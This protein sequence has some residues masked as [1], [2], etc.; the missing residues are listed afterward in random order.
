[1]RARLK[2]R[3]WGVLASTLLIIAVVATV[4]FSPVQ[5]SITEE[6][7]LSIETKYVI[8]ASPADLYEYYNTGDSG[9]DAIYGSRW[10]AQTFTPSTAHT[11]TS[12]KLELFRTGSP[13]TVT[14]S[15]KATSSDKPSG[16]D[17]CSGTTNGN[18]LPTGSPYEWREITLGSGYDLSASTMYAVV[19]RISGG[20][21]GNCIK[22]RA[23]KTSPT[24]TGGTA[25]DSRN[26]GSSWSIR[27]GKDFM[28][29][30]WG[31][32]IGGEPNISNTPTS[33]NF[34]TVKTD[35]EYDT[36]LTYFA[37]TNNSGAAV[38]ITI[39][40]TDMTGG[41]AWTLSDTATQGSDTVG[42]KAGTSSSFMTVGFAND[43][44]MPII[45]SKNT[46]GSYL[47]AGLSGEGY[48]T[49]IKKN[50]PYNY[51][52]Q[53]LADAATQRWG[54]RLLTPTSYSDSNTKTGT[55]TLTATLS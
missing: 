17:L 8:L 42:L 50:T 48:T 3:A 31:D 21:S 43:T 30:D 38:D 2:P 20:S 28:F 55:V 23:D 52:V 39:Q 26:S 15:I 44:S 41:T 47:I 7:R 10:R 29:E 13:G 45:E 6:G 32:P 18:T 49:I 19:V 4:L 22:W 27:T 9:Q 34:G 40:G 37:V 5:I 46:T 24:Y 1:M 54:M 51:L 33:Y 12:V 35:L 36:G 53:S 16:A 25:V 11:I 14:V